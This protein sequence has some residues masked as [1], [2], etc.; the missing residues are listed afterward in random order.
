M[1][2][3]SRKWGDR[4]EGAQGENRQVHG[5]KTIRSSRRSSEPNIL[6]KFLEEL[7][8]CEFSGAS[9]VAKGGI[10]AMIFNKTYEQRVRE[11]GLEESRRLQRLR[12]MT[13]AAET[14][15][16]VMRAAKTEV[17]SSDEREPEASSSDE[18]EGEYLKAA[19]EFAAKREAAKERAAENLRRSFTAD[20]AQG[21]KATQADQAAK[22]S[23]G[24]H[25]EAKDRGLRRRRRRTDAVS[26]S[27]A[28]MSGQ[29]G[30]AVFEAVAANLLVPGSGSSVLVP[31]LRGDS[32]VFGS[33]SSALVPELKGDSLV[34]GSSSSVLVPRLGGDSP[35]SGPSSPAL[36]TGCID[37]EASWASCSP[38]AA[39]LEAEDLRLMRY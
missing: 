26:S 1:W 31:G 38:S 9:K 7:T 4:A 28:V 17:S 3:G 32:P 15:G 37:P 11:A 22:V 29:G 25:A 23:A 2:F 21:S 34:S 39:D 8:K 20:Q 19:I 18:S 14:E 13:R 24:G 5:L 35:V 33:S 12:A 6:L 10:S 27:S 30:D 36:A 16:A